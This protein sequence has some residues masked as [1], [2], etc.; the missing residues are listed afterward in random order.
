MCQ[1]LNV[2]ELIVV[3]DAVVSPKLGL[4]YFEAKDL[5]GCCDRVRADY[6][7]I[8]RKIS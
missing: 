5:A 7:V 6:P 8:V 2:G 1:I 4:I 3:G